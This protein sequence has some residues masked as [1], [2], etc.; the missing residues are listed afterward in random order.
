M[1]ITMGG[2]AKYSLEHKER[3]TLS[4]SPTQKLLTTLLTSNL[5]DGILVI[6]HLHFKM[7]Q[8]PW[9]EY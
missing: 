1:K 6:K 9:V 5:G 3:K 8:G 2:K 4:F 7:S